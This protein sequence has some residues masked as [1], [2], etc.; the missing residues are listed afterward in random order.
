MSAKIQKIIYIIFGKFG[1]IPT[2]DSDVNALVQAAILAQ[3]E[4]IDILDIINFTKK[5]KNKLAEGNI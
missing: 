5:Y 4:G 1:C 2:L 3:S